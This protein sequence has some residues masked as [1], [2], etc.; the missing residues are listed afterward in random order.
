MKM[1]VKRGSPFLALFDQSSSDPACVLV[2]CV[3]QQL[4]VFP[5][6]I[7]LSWQ[8]VAQ[9]E[10]TRLRKELKLKTR[11]HLEHV[12]ELARLVMGQGS[13]ATSDKDEE[14]E[15]RFAEQIEQ[16]IVCSTIQPATVL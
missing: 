14:L 3:W 2:L 16:V 7:R 12:L 6:V 4:H 13:A 15:R 9:I 1:T 5:S 11:P 8:H 10:L